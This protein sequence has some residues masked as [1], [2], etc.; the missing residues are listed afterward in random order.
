MIK[1]M[2]MEFFIGIVRKDMKAIGKME[3][4]MEKGI[5]LLKKKLSMASGLMVKE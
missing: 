5:L 3:N 4:N 2:G 1:N